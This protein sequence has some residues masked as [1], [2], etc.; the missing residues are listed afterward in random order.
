[1][2]GEIIQMSKWQNLMFE[3]HNLEQASPAT[4]SR[5]V[6]YSNIGHSH[7]ITSRPLNIRLV[8]FKDKKIVLILCK[9]YYNPACSSISQ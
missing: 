4:I 2:S 8:P 1:M 6:T 5:W 7:K 3:V 9:S